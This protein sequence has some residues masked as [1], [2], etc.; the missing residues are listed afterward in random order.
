MQERPIFWLATLG[1]GHVF[2]EIHSNQGV[3]PRRER[4]NLPL[5]LKS[6]KNG[7]M[8]VTG[9]ANAVSNHYGGVPASVVIRLVNTVCS[10]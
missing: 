7:K 5:S 3:C 1:F 9:F 2:I 8:L 10:A 4:E 6:P